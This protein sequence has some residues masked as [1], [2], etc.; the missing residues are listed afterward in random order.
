MDQLMS[1]NMPTYIYSD[2][3]QLLIRKKELFKK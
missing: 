2:D 3:L 1:V